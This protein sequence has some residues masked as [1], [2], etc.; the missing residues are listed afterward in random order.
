MRNKFI[1]LVLQALLLTLASTTQKLDISN[2]QQKNVS[3]SY[4]KRSDSTSFINNDTPSLSKIESKSFK[5]PIFSKHTRSS[6]EINL[7][8]RTAPENT[9]EKKLSL[10]KSTS[11]SIDFASK[12][13][14][15][16]VGPLMIAENTVMTE[17]TTISLDY[18]ISTTIYPEELTSEDPLNYDDKKCTRRSNNE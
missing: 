2:I 10:R 4:I 17:E 5:K 8:P 11:T 16:L 18:G 12:M 1:I 3:F 14:N 13:T 9:V 15:E 6:R 7:K